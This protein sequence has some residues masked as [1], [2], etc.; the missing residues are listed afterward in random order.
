MTTKNAKL[1]VD[2][3]E[4]DD[5]EFQP[6]G[7]SDDDDEEEDAELGEESDEIT[8]QKLSPLCHDPAALAR[9]ASPSLDDASLR[10]SA[11][12]P[13]LATS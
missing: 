2:E 5:E 11:D 1:L 12:R 4:A 8:R 6:E 13:S 10:V 7:E 3:K 9:I